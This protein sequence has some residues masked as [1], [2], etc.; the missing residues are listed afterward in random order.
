MK[1]LLTRNAAADHLFYNAESLQFVVLLQ[2]ALTLLGNCTLAF[3][4][5]RLAVSNGWA[6]KL[7]FEE[8]ATPSP[9]VAASPPAPAT[10]TDQAGPKDLLT[11]LVWSIVG[12]YI[13]KYGETLLPLFNDGESLSKSAAALFLILSVTSFNIWKW[14]ERS[15]TGREDFDGLI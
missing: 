15:Q 10:I 5:W 3:A 13:V 4:A 14:N 8:E 2:A 1:L 6:F 7:P 9:S 12:S 11:I